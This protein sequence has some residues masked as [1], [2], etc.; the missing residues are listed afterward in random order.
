MLNHDDI[1]RAGWVFVRHNHVRSWYEREDVIGTT[2]PYSQNIKMWKAQLVHDAGY[3][4]IR[5]DIEASDA[6]T[7]THYQGHCD[8]PTELEL[9]QKLIGITE[10][11]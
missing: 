8:S 7:E 9:I 4:A 2:V 10:T 1:E 11:L 5:I 3:K 6:T